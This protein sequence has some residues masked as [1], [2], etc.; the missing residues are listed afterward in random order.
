MSFVAHA[1]AQVVNGGFETGYFPGWTVNDP[2]A[3]GPFTNVGKSALFAHSGNFHANL[4]AEGLLG[5][6]SQNVGTTAGTNYTLSFWLAND[7]GAP[8][9]EFDVF[10]NGTELLNLVNQPVQLYTEYS[11]NVTA[12]SASTPLVIE[13]RNDTDFFLLDDVS[14]TVAVPEPATSSLLLLALGA[15]GLVGFGRKKLFGR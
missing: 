4:G 5:T 9:N 12:T 6:L 14:A 1:N 2:S 8:T 10:W 3:L 7:G 15:G 13:Y 11:F